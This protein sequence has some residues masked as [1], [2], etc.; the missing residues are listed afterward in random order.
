MIETVFFL[1]TFFF[2][3]KDVVWETTIIFFQNSYPNT[4]LSITYFIHGHARNELQKEHLN[5]SLPALQSNHP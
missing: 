5:S 4:K 3:T 2:Y 1:Q